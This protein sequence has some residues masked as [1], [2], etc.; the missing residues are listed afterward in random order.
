MGTYNSLLSSLACPRCGSIIE[1]SIDCHFGDTSQML[2]LKIGERYPWAPRKK[3][4]NGGRPESGNIVG[5]GYM[6]CPRCHK[7]S[8]V[9]VIV[10]D[11]V[12]SC[13]E[14]DG[15]RHGYLPD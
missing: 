15:D 7:D 3:A 4:Q 2:T 6:E 9:H 1:T 8:F 12:I 10:L 13:I 14:P 11:D 5:E